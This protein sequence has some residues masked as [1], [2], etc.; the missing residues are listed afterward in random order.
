MRQGAYEAGVKETVLTFDNDNMRCFLAGDLMPGRLVERIAYASGGSYAPWGPRL[1]RL[2]HSTG[3]SVDSVDSE[4]NQ[5]DQEDHREDR[6]HPPTWFLFNLEA[7]IYHHRG[8]GHIRGDAIWPKAFR[9]RVDPRVLHG[10]L[11]GERGLVKGT[12]TSGTGTPGTSGTTAAISDTTPTTPTTPIQ[13][14]CSLANNHVLD[15]GWSGLSLTRDTLRYQGV[16][17]AG[18]GRDREQAMRP[19]W[20]TLTIPVA[21]RSGGG[22]G[23]G[24]STSL[25][26]VHFSLS[27]H[28]VEWAAC[29]GGGGE[30]SGSVVTVLFES[31]AKRKNP[32]P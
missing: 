22:G 27:D 4:D 31:Q 6:E 2:L 15:A 21:A 11:I 29:G 30:G 5:E 10:I 9:F 18:C 32:N 3:D 13:L 17:H 25:R 26:I 16:S 23:G 12:S 19:G 20:V 7:A 1:L 8:G 28:P 24:A 14:S